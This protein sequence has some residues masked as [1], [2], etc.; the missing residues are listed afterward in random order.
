MA[1]VCWLAFI[2]WQ[3]RLLRTQRKPLM[4]LRLFA[5]RPFVM[6]CIVAFIYGTAMFGS[7]YL[8]PVFIQM[9]L[10]LSASYAGN[11]LL[12]AGLILAITIP[13]VGRM[14]D[15]QPTHWLTSIGMLLLALSFGLML[16]AGPGMA[17]WLLAGFIIVGRIGLGFI[18]P[19]LNLGALRPID[20]ALI[21]QGSSTISFIRMLGGAIGVGLCG[22]VLEWRL[23]VY[24]S[25][26]ERWMRHKGG[27]RHSMKA[28]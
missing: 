18:L 7:T 12:P 11:L 3:Q 10:G 4:D 27:Y 13:W 19:S 15:T 5:Y 8:L 1:A 25:Q 16:W 9:G 28:L 2:L 17:L 23:A 14:A 26:P 22:I 20:R 21:A 6:G 24:G